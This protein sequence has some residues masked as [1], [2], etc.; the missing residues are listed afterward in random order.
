MFFGL[1]TGVLYGQSCQSDH[2]YFRLGESGWN[3]CD[4]NSDVTGHSLVSSLN[5]II[6]DPNHVISREERE[7]PS[8]AA[9]GSS[10]RWALKTNLL[11]DAML[12]PSLELECLLSKRWSITLEGQCAWWSWSE[13]NYNYQIVSG[14]PELRYWLKRMAPFSGHYLGVFYSGGLY[15]LQYGK[16]GYRGEC[17]L[18]TGLSYGYMK[19]LG[20]KL[21]LELGLGAGYLSTQYEK[22]QPVNGHNVYQSTERVKFFGPLKAKIALVWIWNKNSDKT[23]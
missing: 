10:S 4:R 8:G 14:G 15:D 23:K 19:R 5:G 2:V 6:T 12:M 11:Y 17:Y 1:A 13:K 20:R 3:I 22:Y 9:G 21:S 7:A 16:E 18:C